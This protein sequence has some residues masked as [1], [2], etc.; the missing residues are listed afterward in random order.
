MIIW[1]WTWPF[2]FGVRLGWA[3][4]RMPNPD[5][6]DA[7]GRVYLLRGQGIFCSRGLGVLCG[8]LRECGIWAE[9]LRC[10]GD[11]WALRHLVTDH[12]AGRLRGPIVFVGHSCGARY[13]LYAA[14]KLQRIGIEIAL[15]V[16]LDVALPPRV[17]SNIKKAVNLYLGRK[18]LYPARA[19]RPA[20]AASTI[21]ENIDLSTADS[22]A[23][24]RWLTHLNIIE[25][26][27]VQGIVF[28][29]VLE[30][31][32]GAALHKLEREKI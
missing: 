6:A 14:Y 8:Q 17:P 19:L 20:C 5:I 15:L 9:D 29:H 27:S 21:V 4:T 24:G 13:A 30:A 1:T 25:R 18:R 31:V 10:V 12:R 16:C 7:K 3:S 26:R 32:E 11:L 22:P 2:P 23:A 28:R